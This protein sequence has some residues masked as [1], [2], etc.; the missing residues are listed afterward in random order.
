[1]KVC[2]AERLYLV[3]S[4]QY[5]YGVGKAYTSLVKTDT[6]GRRNCRICEYL[7]R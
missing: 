5:A 6:L 1:M 7:S 4:D 2:E 3:A